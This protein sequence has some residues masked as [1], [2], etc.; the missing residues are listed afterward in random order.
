MARIWYHACQHR[1]CPLCAWLQSERWLITQRARLLAWEHDRVMFPIPRELH[2]LWLANVAVMTT[3]LCASVRDTLLERLGDANYLGARPGIIATL[4]TGTQ[5]LLLHPHI[6]GLVTGG[7]LSGYKFHSR[8]VRHSQPG[9]SNKDI[10]VEGCA[11]PDL[12]MAFYTY[13][14]EKYEPCFFDSGSDHG[15]PEEAFEI[16][17]VYLQD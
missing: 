12:S 14:H 17:A 4:H 15:T 3:L 7:G 5:T 1:L 10:S 9:Q 13:S 16:G 6:H 8:G 11:V 2:A